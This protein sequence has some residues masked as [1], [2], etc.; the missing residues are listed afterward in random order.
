MTIAWRLA[1]VLVFVMLPT[2]ASRASDA[3]AKMKAPIQP[4][5]DKAVMPLPQRN[6]KATNPVRA[7]HSSRGQTK[8]TTS[9]PSEV[10]GELN[11][12]ALAIG[13]RVSEPRVQFTLDPI[14]LE[15]V[16][17]PFVLDYH[18]RVQDGAAKQDLGL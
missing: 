14:P 2:T 8:K 12:S 1:F 10:P 11:F 13:G 16:D 7:V 18:Q 6:R 15:M 3:R 5:D 4:D 17:E 9:R